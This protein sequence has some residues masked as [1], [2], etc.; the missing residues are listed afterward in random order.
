MQAIIKKEY[1]KGFL[2]NEENLIKLAI[3]AIKDL[4]N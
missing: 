1:S 3:F 4:K 2:L